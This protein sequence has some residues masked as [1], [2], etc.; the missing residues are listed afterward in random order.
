[1]ILAKPALRE[2]TRARDGEDAREVCVEFGV[3]LYGAPP[4]LPHFC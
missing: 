2:A 1:M 3:Q 4:N